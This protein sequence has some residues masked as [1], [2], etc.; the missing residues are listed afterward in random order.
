MGILDFERS[1]PK[2]TSVLAWTPRAG[3]LWRKL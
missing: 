1:I 3:F 2:Y